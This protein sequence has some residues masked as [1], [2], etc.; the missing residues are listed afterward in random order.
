MFDVQESTEQYA[1]LMKDPT[2]KEKYPKLFRPDRILYLDGVIQ[3]TLH[4]IEAYHE[5][6]VHPAMFTHKDPKR[7]AII[8]GGEGTT[9]K[10]VLKHNTLEKVQMVEID[11]EMV[12]SSRTHLP[13]WSDCSDIIGSEDWCVED[14]RVEMYYEDAMAWF[15][16]RYSKGGTMY[17]ENHPKL[18]LII[19]DA[20]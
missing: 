12:M 18:D 8:G 10:E 7:V 16:N 4:N 2:Y 13:E 20:L 19:M 9:L 3:S 11:K 17:H 6:L 5:A 14:K 1:R 15:I